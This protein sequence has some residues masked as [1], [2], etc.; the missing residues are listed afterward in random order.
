ACAVDAAHRADER[1]FKVR[2]A[3][4]VKFQAHRSHRSEGEEHYSTRVPRVQRTFARETTGGRRARVKKSHRE[5]VPGAVAT[6]SALSR[7]AR[8][9][10][11]TPG[12]YRSRY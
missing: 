7:R 8:A 1:V 4:A 2:V 5:S 3:V 6:G 11:L 10:K 9:L 12:R